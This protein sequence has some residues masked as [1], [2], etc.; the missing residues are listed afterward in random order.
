MKKVLLAIGILAA[1]SQAHQAN[2]VTCQYEPDINGYVGIYKSWSGKL[3]T[4]SFRNWCPY[5]IR[6]DQW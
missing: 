5:T 4:A 1:I 2:L 6:L 3:Y